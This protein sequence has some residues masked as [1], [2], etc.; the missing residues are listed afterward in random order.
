MNAPAREGPPKDL[1]W[2]ERVEGRESTFTLN[3]GRLGAIPVLV[4]ASIWDSFFVM[5]WIGLSRV[6]APPQAFLFPIAHA[7]VGLVVTWVALARCLNAT[8][9]VV[10]PRELLIRQSPVPYPGGR[11][12]TPGIDRF[13]VH[14]PKSWLRRAPSVR[15]MLKAGP[16][17]NLRLVLDGLDEVAFV[18]ARLNSALAATR[19]T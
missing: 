8:Q 4:F 2:T 6:H 12:E 1:D 14:E 18:A 19:A 9:I 15:A 11:L 16:A 5:L 10:G 3:P 17:V 7:A 13:E